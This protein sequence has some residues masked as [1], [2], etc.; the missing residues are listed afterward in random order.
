[1]Y[2]ILVINY[3]NWHRE[4]LLLDREKNRETQGISKYNLSG[5]PVIKCSPNSSQKDDNNLQENIVILVLK[6][7]SQVT[8]SH[9]KHL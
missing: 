1:M 9:L 6:L 7:M 4:N 8:K 2:V 3:V 5:Y